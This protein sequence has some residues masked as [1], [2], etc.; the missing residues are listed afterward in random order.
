MDSNRTVGIFEGCGTKDTG[1][2]RPVNSCRMRSNL[3]PYCPVDYTIMKKALYP[4]V[5]HNFSDAVSGDFDG[6]GATSQF[7]AWIPRHIR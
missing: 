5:G 6:D 4:F 1:I 3:P 7:T 2:Y